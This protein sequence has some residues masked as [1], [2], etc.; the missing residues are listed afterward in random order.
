VPA[1]PFIF[2]Y[3][4]LQD[5]N[6]AFRYIGRAMETRSSYVIMMQAIPQFDAIRSDPRYKKYLEQVGLPYGPG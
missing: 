6:E 5:Y 1:T 4:G 2:V 3:L